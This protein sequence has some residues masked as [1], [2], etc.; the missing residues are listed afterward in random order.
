MLIPP[1]GV[2]ANVGP[3]MHAWGVE[4]TKEGLASSVL[5]LHEVD[6]SG[7]GLVVDRLHPLFRKGARV[8]DRLFSNFAEPRIQGWIVRISCL[9]LEHAARTKFRQICRVFRVV[10]QLGLLLR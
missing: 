6:R 4:P 8:F 9:A 1:A 3:Q 5:S 7:R 10:R 2:G